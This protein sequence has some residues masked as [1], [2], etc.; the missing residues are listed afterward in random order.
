MAMQYAVTT[1]CIGRQGNI[2]GDLG[3]P[4][5]VETVFAEEGDFELRL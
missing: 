2:E 3:L 5:R 1:G 4:G